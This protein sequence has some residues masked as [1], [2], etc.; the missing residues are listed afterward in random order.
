[1][2]PTV[3]VLLVR[4]TPLSTLN[5]EPPVDAFPHPASSMTATH[6][7]HISAVARA[8]SPLLRRIAMEPFSFTELGPE[9]PLAS[10]RGCMA[11]SRFRFC[12][13]VTE[14]LI[15]HCAPYQLN[16]IAGVPW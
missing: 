14:C 8:A 16:R 5:D 12:Q 6:A 13:P 3:M 7:T 10:A 4:S 1:M 11:C 9:N 2:M 15:G